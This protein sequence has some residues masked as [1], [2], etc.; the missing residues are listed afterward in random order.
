MI[1]G[2]ERPR[3]SRA[4]HLGPHRRVEWRRVEGAPDPERLHAALALDPRASFW[5][6]S[7]DAGAVT[8]TDGRI[9]I[10]GD[11]SGPLAE[12]LRYDVTTARWDVRTAAGRHTVRAAFHDHLRSLLASC[13]VAVPEDLPVDFALGWVGALGYQLKDERMHPPPHRSTHPDAALILADRAVVL[14]HASATVLLLALVDDAL[15]HTASAAAEWFTRT[16]ATIKATPPATAEPPEPPPPGLVR[17]PEDTPP[18]FHLDQDEASYI[19]SIERCLQ[20]IRAGDS[21]EICLTNTATGAPLADP[22][23]AYRALRRTSPVPYGA[24]L[25]FDD[26]AILSASPERFLRVTG[27]G[28]VQTRPIKGTVRR[29]AEHPRITKPFSDEAWA[30]LNRL[31]HQVDAAVRARAPLRPVAPDR[32]GGA[33]LGLPEVIVARQPFPGPGLG[34]RIIGEVTER[35]LDILRRADAI[36]RSELTA[37]GLDA[38]IWQCPVV[39]LADVRSVGV[40]GDGRTYGH[41]IVLRPVSSE[42]A[43]TADWTR[44]PYEVLAQI[45]NRITNE[46]EEVNRVVLDVTSKPPG[47]I[48]WE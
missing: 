21:Y 22:A 18:R 15:P 20:H 2:D 48:E 10:M 38:E 41:P 37:A 14:D 11:A 31:G 1:P 47:T 33:E 25:R 32:A 4:Q 3:A 12:V 7:S 16:S 35:N 5:L 46:V 28:T 36:A 17:A 9:S 27:D 40:Q 30:D 45:S 13:P 8:A 34:I 24:L 26:L 43:M 29:V 42:D 39:L 23:A 44:V 6:D 19:A